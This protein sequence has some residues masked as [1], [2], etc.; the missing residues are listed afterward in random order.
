MAVRAIRGA[1]TVE[2][3]ERD[4]II[5][6]TR[7]LL[8]ELISVNHIEQEDMVNIFFTMT[9]DLNA[10]FPTVAA[11]EMG[12]TNVPL[13]NACE[14]DVPGSLQKCIRVIIY[15]NTD[16]KLD[17]MIHVYLKGAVVLRP[18]LKS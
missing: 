8:E 7:Q 6:N 15:Q 10:V 14:I 16:K 18:D 17:E 13:M 2:N 9:R 1:I 3:N 11:R 12:L 5:R 4:E